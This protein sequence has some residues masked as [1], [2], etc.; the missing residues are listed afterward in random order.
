MRKR[1]LW[2]KPQGGPADPSDRPAG[3]EGAGRDAGGIQKVEKTKLV[4]PFQSP[5]PLLSVCRC[6]WFV[7][8]FAI[9]TKQNNSPQRCWHPV[10][11]TCKEVTFY[12]DRDF[13]DV[14]RRSSRGGLYR[15]SRR[16][17]WGSLSEGGRSVSV[18]KDMTTEAQIRETEKDLKMLVF[19]RGA[20][21]NEQRMHITSREW[22]RQGNG[23][24]SGTS[25]RN[26]ALPTPWF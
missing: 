20:T 9:C 26:A 24:N 2:R 17:Q 4:T 16:G 3:N 7:R 21:S 12:G 15:I 14:K 22:K 19:K 23:L 25:R 5:L 13:T 8:L 6:V 1:S 10:P 11:R 18:G